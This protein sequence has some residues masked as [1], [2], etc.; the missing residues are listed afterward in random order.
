[1][2]KGYSFSRGEGGGVLIIAASLL[3]F[4]STPAISAELTV[5]KQIEESSESF[6][7]LENLTGTMSS[8]SFFYWKK[9]GQQNLEFDNVKAIE[10]TNLKNTGSGSIFKTVS[11]GKT[12]S[13]T[14]LISFK[15]FAP[16]IYSSSGVI[17]SASGIQD[18]VIKVHQIVEGDMGDLTVLGNTYTASMTSI[19]SPNPPQMGVFNVTQGSAQ[20]IR[21]NIRSITPKNN[22]KGTVILLRGDNTNSNAYPYPTEQAFLGAIGDVGDDEHRF[23]QGIVMVRQG[24]QYIEKMGTLYATLY[25]IRTFETENGSDEKLTSLGLPTGQYIKSIEK[26]DLKSTDRRNAS[27]GIYSW[28]DNGNKG[29][30][31]SYVGIRGKKNTAGE[32]VGIEINNPN[33][34]QPIAVLNMGGVQEVEALNS[35]GVSIIA[36]GKPKTEAGKPGVDLALT[37]RIQGQIH[38]HRADRSSILTKTKFI[39][40]FI[41]NNRVLVQASVHQGSLTNP[42]PPLEKG[43]SVVEFS[44]NSYGTGSVFNP[45]SYIEVQAGTNKTALDGDVNP[46]NNTRLL[47][48]NT[49]LTWTYNTYISN[50]GVLRSSPLVNP[51]LSTSYATSAFEFNTVHVSDRHVSP[52]N[53]PKKELDPVKPDPDKPDPD[54]PDSEDKEPSKDISLIT[55]IALASGSSWINASAG[56][57]SMNKASS[58]SVLDKRALT[59]ITDPTNPDLV[60]PGPTDPD[61]VDPDIDKPDQPDELP[62]K[63]PYGNGPYM[64]YW[65]IGSTDKT[66]PYFYFAK[67][68]T[69]DGKAIQSDRSNASSLDFYVKPTNFY[70]N[71]T[72]ITTLSSLNADNLCAG[73]SCEGGDR[74][75]SPGW[76]GARNDK[77][78][79]AA[80][81]L[82]RSAANSIY[83]KEGIEN[84]GSQSDIM[85]KDDFEDGYN[86]GLSKGTKWHILKDADGNE[87]KDDSGNPIIRRWDPN[88]PDAEFAKAAG[89]VVIP[90]GVVNHA[91][92]AQWYFEDIELVQDSA[93]DVPS[94]VIGEGAK[95]RGEIIDL[96]TWFPQYPLEPGFTHPL[97][98]FPA[99]PIPKPNPQ[100]TPTMKSIE[101][102]SLSHYFTWRQEIDTLHQRLGEVRDN[103]ELEGLWARGYAGRNRIN[104][105]GYYF[106]DNYKG[107]QI[108]LD[109]NYY[110]YKDSYRCREKDGEN[111]PCKREKKHDWTYGTG[112]SYTEGDLKLSRGG[113]ADNWMA[114]WWLYGVRKFSNGGYLDLVGKVSRFSNEFSAWSSDYLLNTKGRD[115]TWGY[116]LSAEYGNKHYLF[117]NKDWYLDPQLQIVYGRIF[118]SSFR[119]N[120]DVNVHHNAVNSL[121]GRAGVALGYEGKKGSAFVK[122]D[123]LREFKGKLV[124]TY[125]LD[126]GSFNAS[127]FNLKETW[128]EVSAGGTYT[129]SRKKDKLAHFYVKR[130]FA[131][132]LKTDYRVDIGFEYIF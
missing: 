18:S 4:L 67:I 112:L 120:N 87:L 115:K 60:S 30:G 65:A 10:C 5:D 50:L 17:F 124:T 56:T 78:L 76:K 54:T 132:K 73:D 113:N 102:V 63:Y 88:D 34:L 90:E 3:P 38:N 55:P 43:V 44:S 31:R 53:E 21:G 46:Y 39:G 7:D 41:I 104:S 110:E 101:A 119:T 25:G 1:M 42:K 72:K 92:R 32:Y 79:A 62:Y 98:L 91:L 27:Y 36:K 11:S 49:K 105:N 103:Y 83:A 58:W 28:T 15:N 12:E 69:S 80:F 86:K 81:W 114:S 82:L 75:I 93:S 131:S 45:G 130:S 127:R 24:D 106:R 94:S 33:H 57:S 77:R 117:E 16:S 66:A 109:R 37:A 122:V 121:I 13:Q 19:V 85:I 40:P 125:K 29:S 59:D 48:T 95:Y 107:I 47:L 111:F 116:T 68:E 84:V 123:G 126:D 9:P 64:N 2:K 129:F 22:G 70:R 97:P 6:R 99:T 100:P 52:E 118:G 71:G 128:G 26:I 96:A 51:S 14:Q 74:E 108:G 61:P 89:W 35:E 20:Y 23:Y 8:G